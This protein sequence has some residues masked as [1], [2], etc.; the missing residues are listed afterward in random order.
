MTQPPAR[1]LKALIS[2]VSPRVRIFL[3]VG[4]ALLVLGPLVYLAWPRSD[5]VSQAQVPTPTLIPP[6]APT[7]LPTATLDPALMKAVEVTIRDRLPTVT[8]TPHPAPPTAVATPEVADDYVHAAAAARAQGGFLVI[9]STA[10]LELNARRGPST[11]HPILGTVPAGAHLVA[12]AYQPQ[13]EAACPDGWLYVEALPEA[14]L[15]SLPGR[16]WACHTYLWDVESQVASLPV[17]PPT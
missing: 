6:P 12:T 2:I 8:P 3:I 7:P 15:A 11:R 10:A 17:E 13:G 4:A 5:G 9:P 16:A 14:P 1:T